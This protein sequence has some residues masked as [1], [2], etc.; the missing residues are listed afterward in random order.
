MSMRRYKIKLYPW[1]NSAYYQV[2]LFDNPS[3]YFFDGSRLVGSRMLSNFEND[4]FAK[5]I[6][7]IQI[8]FDQNPGE[9]VVCDPNISS[10]ISIRSKNVY[11]SIT[12]DSSDSEVYPREYGV[13]RSIE[14][15]IFQL[16]PLDGLDFEIP[17][18][19]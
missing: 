4:L 10:R 18:L 19:L 15:L 17:M 1:N 11:L 8:P 16:L 9:M 6:K 5:R 7:K 12:W 3:I 13:I 2:F 14:N